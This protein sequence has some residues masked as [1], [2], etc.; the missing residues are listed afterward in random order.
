LHIVPNFSLRPG[1]AIGSIVIFLLS[2]L[3]LGT[4]P[5]FAQTEP[6]TIVAPPQQWASYSPAGTGDSG[7][8]T[9]QSTRASTAPEAG[10]H[11]WISYE[12]GIF[13]NVNS[14]ADLGIVSGAP[15]VRFSTSTMPIPTAPGFIGLFTTQNLPADPVNGAPIQGPAV[16]GRHPGQ[17]MHLG[18]WFNDERSKGVDIE[19]MYLTSESGAVQV[20]PSGNTLAAPNANLFGTTGSYVISQPTT[21]LRRCT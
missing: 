7:G 12:G 18:Y 10:R 4:T 9:A 14:R 15:T 21:P 20:A 5:A 19:G 16:T 13:R 3:S 8:G 11:F 1:V 6:P 17:T 2:V